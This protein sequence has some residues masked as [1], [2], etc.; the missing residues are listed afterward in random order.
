MATVA[1]VS[2]WLTADVLQ[3]CDLY[4]R[5]DAKRVDIDQRVM[6]LRAEDP[7][8]DVLWRELEPLLA[9][10]REVIGRLAKAP[11]TSMPQLR[12]KAEVLAMLL[13]EGDRGRGRG[14]MIPRCETTALAL[15]LADA[16]V[17]WSE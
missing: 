1:F 13:R 8:R 6:S 9:V 17:G 16:I 12:G 14:P 5:L 3:L 4:R 10:L 2:G 11:A 15:A 7:D